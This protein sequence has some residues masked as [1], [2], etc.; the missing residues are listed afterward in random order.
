MS[1]EWRAS[2]I[3]WRSGGC[4]AGYRPDWRGPGREPPSPSPSAPRAVSAGKPVRLRRRLRA[5]HKRGSAAWPRGSRFRPACISTGAA[6]PRQACH[7]TADTG[8]DDRHAV[9]QPLD[10]RCQHGWARPC[11]SWRAHIDRFAFLPATSATGSA[12]SVITIAPR[13]RRRSG[14]S[15][16]GPPEFRA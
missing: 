5:R 7:P 14:I 10:R 8:S 2:V 11:E 13:A 6:R 4:D 9:S 3:S 12:P 16:R 15:A 1:P